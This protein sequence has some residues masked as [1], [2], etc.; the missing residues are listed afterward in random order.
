MQILVFDSPGGGPPFGGGPG[1]AAPPDPPKRG[2]AVSYK[3]LTSSFQLL[4]TFW[5]L[6]FRTKQ[7]C[8]T[9]RQIT[10]SNKLT[11]IF[12]D[13]AFSAEIDAGDIQQ[14]LDDNLL[15]LKVAQKYLKETKLENVTLKKLSNKYCEEKKDTEKRVLDYEIFSRVV[16]ILDFFEIQCGRPLKRWQ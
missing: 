3:T 5:F 11:R 9:C 15:E 16:L 7:S 8:P 13:I 1:A 14:K 2:A 4:L 6:Q 10:E 12:F